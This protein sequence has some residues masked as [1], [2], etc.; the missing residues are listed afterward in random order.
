MDL[1]TIFEKL[2]TQEHCI[3]HLEQAR[4]ADEPTCPFCGSD[5][6]ARK[7]ENERVGRWNCHACKNSYNVL[8]GTICKAT[9]IPLQ[10]WFLAITI[11]LN[12]KKSVSSCQLARDLNITQPTAYRMGM[13]IRKAMIDDS[14][15][16]NGIVEADS[17]GKPRGKRSD[18]D[19]DKPKRG[20]G[21][22]KQPVIGALA[23]G[24]KVVAQ[25][26]DK[27]YWQDAESVPEPLC[28]RR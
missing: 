28:R 14:V 12:A 18:D 24:G 5:K 20:R 27:G 10:K 3:E 6:V 8:S 17:G 1:V 7:Q 23:R 13:Q 11:L 22:K 2:P 19:N 15:F 16:L 9:R 26:S 25:P 4:W 21:T